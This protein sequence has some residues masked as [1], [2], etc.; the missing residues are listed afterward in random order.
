MLWKKQ[1]KKELT[2][3]VSIKEGNLLLSICDTGTG[4]P[5]PIKTKIF[6][7]F[8]TTKPK[9]EGTGLGLSIVKNIVV[10]HGGELILETEVGKGSTFTVKL[11]S[12]KVIR[13]GNDSGASRAA[14]ENLMN[15]NCYTFADE[16]H[17]NR[18]KA[19]V[20]AAKKAVGGNK[21]APLGF[22]ITVEKNLL[23]K[24]SH[25]IILFL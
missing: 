14:W 13:N 25:W 24:I 2:V 1:H 19:K 8:F 4:I 23:L 7:S 3:K 17:I 11:P 22:V 16:E 18:E 6:D 12:S 5:D 9:G 15:L 10:E 21:N 20:K